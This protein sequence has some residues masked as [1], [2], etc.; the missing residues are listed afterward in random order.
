MYN[1]DSLREYKKPNPKDVRHKAMPSLTQKREGHSSCLMGSRLYVF[2]T[3]ILRKRAQP[4]TI[5]YLEVGKTKNPDSLRWNVIEL[6]KSIPREIFE[7]N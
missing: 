7:S 2:A 6:A 4:N 1:L 3:L 5:E